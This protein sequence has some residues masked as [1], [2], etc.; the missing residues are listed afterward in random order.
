MNEPPYEF[1]GADIDFTNLR[2]TIHFIA[3]VAMWQF[4]SVTGAQPMAVG[5]GNGGG[6]PSESTLFGLDGMAHLTRYPFWLRVPTR[7][8]DAIVRYL[9]VEQHIPVTRSR[10]NRM[11]GVH[12]P[13]LESPQSIDGETRALALRE[14]GGLPE[15]PV[16]AAV[17]RSTQLPPCATRCGSQTLTLE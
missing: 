7:H 6:Q 16:R 1:F 17:G 2:M 12:M 13:A 14:A 4:C 3:S 10:N 11:R 15:L 9:N 8:L 5:S